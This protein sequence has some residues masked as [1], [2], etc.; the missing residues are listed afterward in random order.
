MIRFL[1]AFLIFVVLYHILVTVVWYGILGWAYPQL[2]ALG[3]DAI[4]LLFF[5]IIAII[6]FKSIKSYL[7]TWKRPWIT[8]IIIIIFG[9]GISLLKWKWMYDIFVGIKYGLL[10]LYI[11]LS[12]TF[13]GY[14]WNTKSSSI[15]NHES[16][17]WNFL[18]FIKYLLVTTLIAGFL[19]QGLK[20][21]WPDLFLH[22]GYGPFDDFKFGAKPPIYYLTWYQGTSRRQGIFSW[23]NNYGYFLIAFLPAVIYFFKQKFEDI[24]KLA[25]IN[26]KTII[27]ISIIWLW[28]LAI[29]LT[30]SRTAFIGW[31]VALAAINIQ[32]IRKH[33]KISWGIWIALLMGLIWLSILKWASTLGHIKAK[34]GSIQYVIAQPSGYG[35]WTS[36]PAV[37]Y[38]GTILPENYYIQLM[39]DIGTIGFILRTLLILQIIRLA[40][41][42]QE[43]FKTMNTNIHEQTIYLIRIW[44][45]IWRVSLLI[46]WI[47][48]HVFEDSMINYLF[49]ISRGILT[50]YLSTII[51]KKLPNSR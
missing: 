37:N 4:W 34:F 19:R 41:K 50:G 12:A 16:W 15:M 39:L 42:I 46:M 25:I 7:T 2:P 33:K 38:N 35:L 14:I 17:I 43:A 8:F 6:N 49:F 51:D 9:V 23:P 26:K 31:I 48:L 29:A 32:R 22:I 40:R 36:W 13:I 3:R 20:F 10:Y 30:L 28:I 18:N 47:F 24:K 27:N 1:K 11:F 21:I 45:N 5:A 44:L